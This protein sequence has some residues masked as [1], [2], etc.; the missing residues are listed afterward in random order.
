MLTQTHHIMKLSA[1]RKMLETRLFLALGIIEPKE[2][3]YDDFE[4][5]LNRLFCPTSSDTNQKRSCHYRDQWYWPWH[6]F[7]S[8]CPFPTREW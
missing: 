7:Q 4:F 1:V 3:F 6:R 8:R 5:N 2:S